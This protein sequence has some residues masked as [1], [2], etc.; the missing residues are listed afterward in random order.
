MTC[1]AQHNLSLEKQTQLLH[2]LQQVAFAQTVEA[3]QS[4]LMSLFQSA[5]YINNTNVRNYLQ[6]Q[7]LK[8]VHVSSI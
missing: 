7:W 5:V 8:C 1:L 6:S 3:Y 2:H 4:N